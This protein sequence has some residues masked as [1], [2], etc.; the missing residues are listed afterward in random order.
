MSTFLKR[1]LLY[2]LVPM[3]LV[4]LFFPLNTHRLKDT[5]KN[6]VFLKISETLV[7]K[8]KESEVKPKF[9]MIDTSGEKTMEGLQKEL[10]KMQKLFL[11]E[12]TIVNTYG[13]PVLHSNDLIPYPNVQSEVEDMMQMIALPNNEYTRLK[14]LKNVSVE[15]WNRFKK[16]FFSNVDTG[17]FQYGNRIFKGY[18]KSSHVSVEVE[19]GHLKLLS[20]MMGILFLFLSFFLFRGL[21][22]I[23]SKGIQIGKRRIMILWDILIIVITIFFTSAFFD[24]MLV[25][26]FQT[27]PVLGDAKMALFMGTFWVILANPIMALFTTA[28]AMQVIWITQR[29]ITVKGLFGQKIIA[30]SDVENIEISNYFMARK[31]YGFYASRKVMKVLNIQSDVSTIRIMEPPLASI[32]EEILDR[33]ILYAPDTLKKTISD[34]SG[35]W[36]SIW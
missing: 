11:E 7:A 6:F 26:Y 2:L 22:V 14:R 5:E 20:K 3:G 10:Q 12:T 28:T 1:W 8:D 13:Y 24:G 27:T 31:V 36:L 25:H 34:L 23:P 4:L 9:M 30:W 15:E 29:D 19:I 32:K 16:S 17:A 35:E 18:I 33:L 21:Y